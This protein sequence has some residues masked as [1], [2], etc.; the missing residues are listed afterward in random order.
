MK[1]KLIILTILLKLIISQEEDSL[2]IEHTIIGKFY[3]QYS[4]FRKI[5]INKVI[6]WPGE[7]GFTKII[8]ILSNK[9][10]KKDY[11]ILSFKVNDWDNELSPWESKGIKNEYFNGDGLKTINYII[12][13]FLPYFE[14]KFPKIKNK[15]K[16]IGGY[17]LSGLFS[18]YAFYSTDLFIGVG[19]ISPS[20]WFENWNE[21]IHKNE[22]KN[23]GS[24]VYLSLGDIEE[25]NNEGDLS[26]G[27]K[28]RDFYEIISK[29][30]NV[31]ECIYEINEGDHFDN[32][33]YRI[34][35]G[36]AW[37]LDKF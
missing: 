7:F 10:L 30:L 21:F 35:K 29:D 22:I 13:D 36:F 14:N 24:Y 20:L 37:L 8:K 26:I 31:K 2:I 25:K 19:G 9:T 12:N 27:C 32:V 4:Y 18:L 23:N 28:V 6:I 17:S 1:Y 15:P 11:L 16:I 3:C 33:E 34:A 5:E